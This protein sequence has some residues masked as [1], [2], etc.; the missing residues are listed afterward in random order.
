MAAFLALV[1]LAAALAGSFEAG[2]WYYRMNKPPWTP[3]AWLFGPLWAVLYLMM[4]IS[5]WKIWLT[6]HYNRTGALAWW[7]IVLVLNVAWSW[8]FFGLNRIGWAWLESGFLVVVTIFCI[9]A[10]WPLSK[11]AARLMLPLLA[12]LA[13][14][15]V[16][17]LVIWTMNRGF[18]A[19]VLT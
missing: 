16:L 1:V 12:W 17:N 2:D 10:F 11:P 15:W 18:L 6:G 7:V 5:A 13:F 9:K 19:T 14:A 4:A 3:P 8:L